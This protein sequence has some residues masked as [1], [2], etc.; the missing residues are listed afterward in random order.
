MMGRDIPAPTPSDMKWDVGVLPPVPSIHR[1]VTDQSKSGRPAH[2]HQ[3]AAHDLPR[4]IKCDWGGWSAAHKCAW[5]TALS[6]AQVPTWLPRG[7]RARA[8][9]AVQPL[10]P[11]GYDKV[12]QA[13]RGGGGGGRAAASWPNARSSEGRWACWAR[14]TGRASLFPSQVPPG[15]YK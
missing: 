2:V 6:P 10:G 8:L 5:W 13:P 3:W 14:R 9:G 7:G 15:P 4:C 11:E 12:P 1:R